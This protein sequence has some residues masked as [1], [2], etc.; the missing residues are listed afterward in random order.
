[1]FIIC[2]H[3]TLLKVLNDVTGK[4]EIAAVTCMIHENVNIDGPTES[5][6]KVQA[7]TI[8]RQVSCAVFLL[9]LCCSYK[10][11]GVLYHS[12]GKF[13]TYKKHTTQLSIHLFKFFRQLNNTAWPYD[14]QTTLRQNKETTKVLL[15]G[16]ERALCSL[17]ISKL[18]LLDPDVLLGHGLH[19]PSKIRERL[20]VTRVFLLYVCFMRL[21]DLDVLLRHGLHGPS[22]IR[23]RVC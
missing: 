9:C 6:K 5:P 11:A 12:T 1:M 16:N 2:Q 14:L 20:H 17:L 3:I 21:L 18:H 23:E 10:S 13:T 8:I 22:K 4:Q 7:F 19:G 15:A